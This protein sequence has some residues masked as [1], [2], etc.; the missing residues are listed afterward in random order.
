MKK[1]LIF[2]IILYLFLSSWLLASINS[3]V[4]FIFQ[5]EDNSIFAWDFESDTLETIE[6]PVTDI[7][8]RIKVSP[9]GQTLFFSTLD[10]TETKCELIAFDLKKRVITKRIQLDSFGMNHVSVIETDN[11]GRHIWLTGWHSEK[12]NGK[13]QYLKSFLITIDTMSF[14]I[15][16]VHSSNMAAFQFIAFSNDNKKVYVGVSVCLDQTSN[17]NIVD[18]YSTETYAK[19]KS[20]VV[21]SEGSMP[22]RI[23]RGRDGYLIVDNRISG[24]LAKIDTKTDEVVLTKPGHQGD[25]SWH[26]DSSLSRNLLFTSLSST[27]IGVYDLESLE[28]V[29]DIPLP[30]DDIF[31]PGLSVDQT[32]RFVIYGTFFWYW[33]E[34][35]ESLVTGKEI[36]VFDAET[37]ETLKVLELETEEEFNVLMLDIK[38]RR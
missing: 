17:L 4:Y 36:R 38:D 30:Y 15:E 10:M 33:D 13:Y 37:Y 5:R 21:G 28:H 24:E 27:M 14:S 22:G 20:I 6:A 34:S 16:N 25:G 12:I 23:I 26:S 18:V 2:S 8:T 11:T 3:T 35:L 9:D 31:A 29:A 32:G 1:F 19:L 7:I